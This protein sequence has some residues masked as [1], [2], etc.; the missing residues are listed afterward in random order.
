MKVMNILRRYGAPVLLSLLSA[1]YIAQAQ[2]VNPSQPATGVPL[3]G[4]G[5]SVAGQTVS[6]NYGVANSPFTGNMTV[7]GTLG[8]TGATT[9]GATSATTLSASSTVSGAGF[10]AFMASPPA[11]GSTVAS[12]GA[13]TTLGATGTITGATLTSTG[14]VNGTSVNVGTGTLTAGYL[15]PFTNAVV[16]GYNNKQTD[17]PS[18]RDFGALCDGSTNDAVAIQNAINY[19]SALNIPLRV[20]GAVCVVTPATAQ[21]GAASYNT[22]LVMASHMHLVGD[23]G[24]T[25]KISDNYSTNATPKEL[26]MFSTVAHL[27][28]VTFEGLIFDMN[29]ANN[30]MSPA[31]PTTYNSFNH[32]AIFVNG[33]TGYMDDVII[34]RNQ[35]KNTAGVCFIVGQLVAAG[36]TPPMGVRW[37]ILDNVFLNGGTDSNDHTSIFAWS[38]DTIASGNTFWED[39]PPYT[40][41]QTGGHTCY[42]IHGSHARFLGNYCYNYTLGVYVSPNFTNTTFDVIVGNNNFLTT[43]YGVLIWRWVDTGVAYLPINGVLIG[44]NTFTLIPYTYSGQ[45][46]YVAAIAYQ[47]QISSK[48]AAVFNIK[49][50][51]NIATHTGT[52]TSQFVH[53][54]TSTTASQVSSNLSVTDNQVTGFND[55]FYMVTNSVGPMGYT[56]VS[57]NQFIALI[58]DAAV[59]P[60][61]GIYINGAAGGQISTLVMDANQFVDEQA[62]PTMQYGIYLHAGLPVTTLSM[63]NQTFKNMQAANAFNAGATITSQ[64]GAAQTCG[65]NVIADGGTINYVNDFPGF[66]VKAITVTGS[67]AGEIPSVTTFGATTFTTALKKW[68]GGVLTAGTSQTAY[69]C[70][71]F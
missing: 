13:F 69:W 70:A 34:A 12:T 42:E 39:N 21:A 54:D 31:R 36:T 32:A 71:K 52:K 61:H 49:I 9:L 18:V 25:I 11:I 40:V 27:T 43:D 33:P 41:G 8:V 4:T 6:V 30:L 65:A 26:A 14:A 56:E 38:E 58:P 24:A 29:G 63:G 47:G 28:D 2:V 17:I 37:K 23:H 7:G 53:W 20:P 35:F 67:V 22:A 15:A 59:N 55:G 44:N 3:A 62:T 10:N 64:I 1:S 48:Q 60:P 51:N 66:T 46:T 57:R 5:I 45:P 68:T 19:T 16:R 50:A